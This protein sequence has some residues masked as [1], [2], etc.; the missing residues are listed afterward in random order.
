MPGA[1]DKHGLPL[2][3]TPQGAAGWPCGSLA[4]AVRRHVLIGRPRSAARPVRTQETTR[5]RQPHARS[6]ELR[7]EREIRTSKK[8]LESGNFAKKTLSA[9]EVVQSSTQ[10]IVKP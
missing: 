6:R 2:L 3:L 7:E 10:C 4:P 5:G 9:R 8:I 1:Q